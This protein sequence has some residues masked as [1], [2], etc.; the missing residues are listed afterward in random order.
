MVRCNYFETPNI[1]PN[2][3]DQQQLRLIH[4]VKDYY[5]VEIKEREIMSTMFSKYRSSLGYFD[6]S[7]IVLSATSGSISIA[8]FATATAQPTRIASASFS[9]AFLDVLKT[10]PNKENTIELL[11]QLRVNQTAQKR[12]SEAIINNEYSG[13]DFITIIYK[14]RKYQQ[15]KKESLRMVK[16][17]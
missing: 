8:S 4:K 9:A 11:S 1:Y 7:L 17:Q 16:S 3:N 10:T 5:M 6:K 12:N 15:L 2:V 13:Q 14:E